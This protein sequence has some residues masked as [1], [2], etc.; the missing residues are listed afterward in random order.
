MMV[1]G[2]TTYVM[3]PG[4]FMLDPASKGNIVGMIR[5]MTTAF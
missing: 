5:E 4:F 1:P 2:W 3:H